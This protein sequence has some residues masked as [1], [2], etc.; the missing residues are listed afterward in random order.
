LL[1]V[2]CVVRVERAHALPTIMRLNA[3][4]RMV[5]SAAYHYQG[6]AGRV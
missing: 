1:C 4:N 5:G 6:S 2:F 3:D